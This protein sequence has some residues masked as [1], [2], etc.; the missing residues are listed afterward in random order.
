MNG[1]PHF[2]RVIISLI[3][4]GLFLVPVLGQA[5]EDEGAR[6]KEQHNQLIK[7]LKL[8]PEKEKAVLA[9]KDKFEKERQ[10]L[11]EGMKKAND[12]LKA[13]LA[14]ANPDGAK[15]KELVCAITAGQD[16][17]FASF[18]KQRDQ[19]MAL[20][21]PAEQGKYLMAMSQWRQKMMEQREKT[22]PG[23]KK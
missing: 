12:D 2:L 4:T 13:L 11:I 15:L 6:Y 1:K 21:T 3:M 5:K 19:E 9:V 18:K 8:A 22:A 14:A 17:L 10:E 16:N 7:D 23:E 20:M